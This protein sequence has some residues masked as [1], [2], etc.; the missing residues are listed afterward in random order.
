MDSEIY[1]YLMLTAAFAITCF[2]V[3]LRVID[4]ADT[5]LEKLRKARN[6]LV[7]SYLV[8]AALNLV[9]FFTGYDRHI[10]SASTLVVASFQALLFT[11]A[12]VVFVR[13]DEVKWKTVCLHSVGIAAAGI[14]L[15]TV[16]F[17]LPGVYSRI[18]YIGLALYIV[19]L[20]AY[21]RIFLRAYR[22]TVH[23][24]EDYYDDNEEGRLKWV[25]YGFYGALSIGIMAIPTM[26]D[27]RLYIV[28]DPLYILFYGAMV[29]WFGNYC[30]KMHFALPVISS[31]P[32]KG[33]TAVDAPAEEAQNTG[34]AAEAM[35]DK[36]SRL[37]ERLQKYVTEKEYCLRDIPST[38]LAES[39]GT[40]KSFL[41]A[42]MKSR[43]GTDF[44]PWRTQLRME[45]ACRIFREHPEYTSLQVCDLVGV[46]DAS[47]FSKNFK[48]YTGKRPK[49]YRKDL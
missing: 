3:M 43:M 32:G 16:L 5:R 39:L 11:M 33:Q 38:T 14:L 2:G 42:F 19:Q 46:T 40:S 18:F 31:V 48:K 37:Q 36:E 1:K 6:L 29:S 24:V 28:F 8:L 15:F 7:F 41:R 49:E 13:P 20:I 4:I 12:T 10:E 44:G 9:C 26:L 47:D 25:K 17:C 27:H 21:T 35:S 34:L 23:E 22:Q 30:H 45:E